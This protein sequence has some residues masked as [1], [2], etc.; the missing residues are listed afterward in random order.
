MRNRRI[1]WH[2]LASVLSSVVLAGAALAAESPVAHFESDGFNHFYNNEYD[3]ALAVFDRQIQD[4]PDDALAYNALAQTILYREMYRNGA[5]ESELVAGNNLFLHRSKIEISQQDRERFNDAINRAISLSQAKLD[6]NPQ[7]V[8]ALYT[9]AVAHGLRANFLFSV[10]KSWVQALRE[11]ITGRRAN[12]KILEIDPSFVDAH[13]IHGLS[14]YVVSCL[15]AYLRMLGKFNGFHGDKE[16]GIKQLQM[17]SVNGIRNRY[18]ASILLAVIYRRE[19]RSND[20][21]PL[22]D[23][24]A[25]R[26]PRNHLF[27]FEQV[28][29]YSDLGD[30][31]S[32]LSV[33]AGIEASL[34]QGKPGYAALPL[35]R[36]RYARGNLLFWYNDLD[37]SLN[38][39][40][41][42][43][44]H[45][46]ELDASTATM[47]WL[48][49]GQVYDLL[50]DHPKAI[51]AY[52]MAISTAPDS[53]IA[54]EASDY[55]DKPYKRKPRG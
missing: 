26:F 45:P 51:N 48:R 13:L 52:R 21:I 25:T 19:H 6:Q 30:E 24:L 37:R 31:A 3:Q 32:A 39:L 47:A 2:F 43:T 20:A 34:N 7:D 15:P 16:D 1:I 28:Q 53:E 17:V 18:D 9:L 40:T 55:V 29:M 42:V 33:L 35:E 27:R 14:E 8:R 41:Q 5:L 54:K 4:A 10:D 12:D 49:L 38:D 36:V 46:N 22:L 11:S 23:D 50:R 44:R